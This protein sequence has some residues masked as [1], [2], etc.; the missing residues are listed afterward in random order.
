VGKIERTAREVFGWSELHPGQLQAIRAL[1]DGHDTLVVMPTG[2]GKSAIYQI[3]ALL[4]GGPTVVVSPLVALQRDQL[5]GLAASRAPKAVAVNSAQR[6]RDSDRAWRALAAGTAEFLFL[7]PEQL[8]KDEVIAQLGEH[9]PSLLVVDEAHCVSSWGHDFRPD[10]LRLGEAIGRLGHPRVLA[11][12]ATA[13]R[14]VREEIVGRLDMRQPRQVV[15]GFDRPNLHLEVRRFDRDRD[16]R[17]AAI[18]LAVRQPKP[19]LVYV[20]TRRDTERYAAAL[21][22]RGLR[23]AAYHAGLRA[24]ERTRTHQRFSGDDLDVVVAT[25][26]FGMGIDKPNVRFVLHAAVPDSLDSY[27]Q[28]IGRA[29]R[30]GEPAAATL[31][32]RPQDLGVQRFHAGGAPDDQALTQVARALRRHRGPVSSGRLKDGVKLSATKLT[33]MV[34]LLEQ[35]GAVRVVP[36]GRLEYPREAPPPAQAVERAMEIAEEHRRLELSR[37]EMM[38]EYAETSDC[39]RQFLLGYF[40]ERLDGRCGHCDT[41]QAG[42]ASDRP[43]ADRD[44]AAFPPGSLV[45][46]RKLGPGVVMRLEHDRLTV[47]FEQTGYKTLSLETVR[48]RGLLSRA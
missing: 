42:T 39:R 13:A 44:A 5:A 10:Y 2:A 8:A 33:A 40:G 26:A 12:T 14:P 15:A 6:E 30:D 46:H 43:P 21:R 4:L 32:Y 48:R 18:E 28:E 25:C 35:A 19:G 3:T 7:T 34:N 47:L 27:Y 22:E 45:E 23:A 31:L 17:Q 37:V 20:A 24:A 38:R 11:L 9:L 41:C 36:D 16:K 29:G 1:L